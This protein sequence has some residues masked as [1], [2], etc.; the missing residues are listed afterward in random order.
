MT[1]GT[2]D[3]GGERPPSDVLAWL[4]ET[5]YPEGVAIW[6]AAWRIAPPEERERMIRRARTDPM[7]T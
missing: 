2:P 5:Y 1:P 4:H 3:A 7:G 6:L